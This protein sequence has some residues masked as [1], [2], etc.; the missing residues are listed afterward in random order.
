MEIIRVQKAVMK[1]EQT[2]KKEQQQK[3]Y[4]DITFGEFRLVVAVTKVIPLVL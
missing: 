3:A 2:W 4:R 1:E